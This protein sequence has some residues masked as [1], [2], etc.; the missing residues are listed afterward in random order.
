MKASVDNTPMQAG[1][2]A[3]SHVE[4]RLDL[5]PARWIA[6]DGRHEV[7]RLYE[8]SAATTPTGRAEGAVPLRLDPGTSRARSPR[9]APSAKRPH[10]RGAKLRLLRRGVPGCPPNRGKLTQRGSGLCRQG[11]RQGPHR[12]SRASLGEPDRHALEPAVCL[13]GGMVALEP[14]REL[15]QLPTPRRAFSV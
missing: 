4:H 6:R 10:S 7:K 3:V 15:E 1:T 8:A 12:P 13:L 14:C 5:F 9:S 2:A 11:G